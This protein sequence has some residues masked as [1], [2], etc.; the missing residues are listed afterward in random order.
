MGMP[1]NYSRELP[2]LPPSCRDASPELGLDLIPG[3]GE[4]WP[5]DNDDMADDEAAL[6]LDRYPRHIASRGDRI[7]RSHETSIL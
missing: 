5:A 2:A 1:A 3:S 7:R 4:R 6:I